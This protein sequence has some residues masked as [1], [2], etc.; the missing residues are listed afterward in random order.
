MGMQ[1]EGR[2]G[3]L[4]C[5]RTI[6]VQ[7]AH[8]RHHI[9]ELLGPAPSLGSTACIIR[10]AGASLACPWPWIHR[11]LS[12]GASMP[13]PGLAVA[14]ANRGACKGIVVLAGIE[15][16]RNMTIC[17]YEYLAGERSVT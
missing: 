7:S 2:T 4:E 13:W 1:V 10:A 12:P 17:G 6:L 8:R 14:N 3:R 9:S 15:G 16:M 11:D 5:W